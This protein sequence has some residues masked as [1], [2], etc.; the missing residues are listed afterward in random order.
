MWV[1]QNFLFFPQK[2]VQF[3]FLLLLFFYKIIFDIFKCNYFFFLLL[4]ILDVHGITFARARR[5]KLMYSLDIKE[6][7]KENNDKI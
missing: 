7:L 6:M 3:L 4:R 1:T 5:C 2:F